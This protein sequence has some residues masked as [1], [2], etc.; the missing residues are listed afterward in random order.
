MKNIFW[1]GSRPEF[2]LLALVGTC[3]AQSPPEATVPEIVTDRPDVTESSIVVPKASLQIEKR[4][5]LNT[6][7]GFQTF[8]LSES[9]VRLG[10]SSSEIR[11]VVPNYLGGFTGSDATGF[12]DFALGMKQ[13]LGPLPG[14][15]DLS[16]IVALSRACVSWPQHKVMRA[17]LSRRTLPLRK[18]CGHRC[19]RIACV[20]GDPVT[21]AHTRMKSGSGVFL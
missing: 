9:L 20:T 17:I 19:T 6:D 7:H 3:Y 10:V 14:G 8:D 15:F 11:L 2:L 18:G 13:Q 5:H 21:H 4:G 12:G 16:V 1:R